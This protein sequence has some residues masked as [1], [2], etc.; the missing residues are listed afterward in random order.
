V[1]RQEIFGETRGGESEKDAESKVFDWAMEID[2]LIG[3]IHSISNFS[4]LW[5]YKYIPFFTY[6]L[7]GVYLERLFTLETNHSQALC[8]EY[9]SYYLI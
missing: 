2:M 4:L 9:N 1:R 7:L 5:I 3:P 8:I 6:N